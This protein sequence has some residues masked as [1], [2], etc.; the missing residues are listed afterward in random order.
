[1]GNLAE[2]AAQV[3]HYTGC[4]VPVDRI[5]VP[6]PAY[7]A[8]GDLVASADILAQMVDRCYLEK[9]YDRLYTEFVLGG[10]A[11]KRD[12]QG[13]EQV[14]FASPQDLVIK[15]PGFYRSAKKRMDE[16]LHGAYHYVEKHFNG[17]NLHLEAVEKYP[18]CGICDCPQC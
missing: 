14:I 7:R 10:I 9:C 12:A 17:Q 3:V 15:T 6:S 13:H 16:T 2:T 8:I 1:M 11:K 5:L 4:E 18:V